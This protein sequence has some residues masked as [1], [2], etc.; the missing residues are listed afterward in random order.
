MVGVIYGGWRN[1]RLPS[2]PGMILVALLHIVLIMG[3][4]RGLQTAPPE[5]APK[6][7]QTV[8]LPDTV[9]PPPPPP[10]LPPPLA[11]TELP[12]LT[13]APPVVPDIVVPPPA[14]SAALA[15][16]PAASVG[17]AHGAAGSPDAG[18]V[19][20]V[21]TE[22]ERTGGRAAPN[23]PEEYQ[24]RAARVRVACIIATDGT[25]QLCRVLTF[26]GGPAFSREVLRWLNG[27]DHPVYAPGQRNGAP[28]REAHE[29]EIRF[30]P[31]E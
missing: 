14:H 26:T 5:A 12:A 28:V 30:E 23:Y 25:P 18:V 4:V 8:V 24:G 3:L 19:P 16:T 15:P 7:L 29:W 27:P 11:A 1:S 22:P 31:V 13:L 20:V 10:P 21:L 2:V 17:Q 6:P 9:L